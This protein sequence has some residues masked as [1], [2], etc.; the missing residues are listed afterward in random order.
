MFTFGRVARLH[1]A[2]FSIPTMVTRTHTHT[3]KS[4]IQFVSPKL[5]RDD[6]AISVNVCISHVR[7]VGERERK[8]K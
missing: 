4:R 2:R 3:S 7:Q 8:Q 1:D 5:R 6:C